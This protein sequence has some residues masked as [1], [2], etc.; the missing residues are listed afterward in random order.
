M[1]NGR[2]IHPN[3]DPS[4]FWSLSDPIGLVDF[5][6]ASIANGEAFPRFHIPPI[7][8][9]RGVRFHAVSVTIGPGGPGTISEPVGVTVRQRWMLAG[10]TARHGDVPFGAGSASSCGNGTGRLKGA[11]RT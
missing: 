5:Q 2:P 6:G 9:L 7:K 8:A 10:R 3:P 11:C 1:A 4:F